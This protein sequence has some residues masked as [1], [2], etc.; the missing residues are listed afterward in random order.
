MLE[1]LSMAFSSGSL[2]LKRVR[3]LIETV[4]SQSSWA[5]NNFNLPSISLVW[6]EY[7][8]GLTRRPSCTWGLGAQSEKLSP[9]YTS[10]RRTGIRLG[11][12]PRGVYAY[13]QDL[14]VQDGSVNCSLF[15]RE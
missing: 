12:C 10:T 11:E 6:C 3:K 2:R 5:L 15:A 1:V 13:E 9:S 8:F 14:D 4:S 7:V